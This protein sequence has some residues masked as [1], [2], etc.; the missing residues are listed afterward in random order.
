MSDK[1]LQ[2][3]LI[4]AIKFLVDEAIKNTSYTSSYIGRVKEV[5]GFNCIVEIYGSDV[6]CKLFEHLQNQIKINDIVVVQDLYNDNTNKFVLCK[7]GEA[8]GEETT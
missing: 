2:E 8:T 5:N 4:Y 7:I 6:E 3:S 1:D